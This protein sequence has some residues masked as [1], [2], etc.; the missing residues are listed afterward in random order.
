MIEATAIAAPYGLHGVSFTLDRGLVALV[1]PNGSGKTTLLRALAGLQPVSGKVRVDGPVAYLPQ[2]PEHL[3]TMCAHD[4]VSLGRAP[5]RG[6]LGKLSNADSDAVADAMART[7]TTAFADRLVGEL[8]GGERARV[9]LARALATQAPILLADEP[10]ASLDIAHALD[11]MERLREASR[12]SI[13]VC[14]LHDL[15]LAARFAD[16]VLVLGEGRLR[17][18]GGPQVLSGDVVE[19]VFGVAPPSGGW[20]TPRRPAK[21]AP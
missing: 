10:T 5:Y 20:Q 12:G 19:R 15:A 2:T 13:V 1:G 14:A 17:A 16:R 7:G 11:M 9:H 6:R 18:D 21:R 3:D 8:S 4:L